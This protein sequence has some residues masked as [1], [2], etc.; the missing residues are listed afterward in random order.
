MAPL[1]VRRADFAY[2]R[3]G[4]KSPPSGTTL[5]GEVAAAAAELVAD[6]DS[7]P[8]RIVLGGRSMGGRV[9]SMA[10]AD[11]LGA[12]GL[13][14][15]AY[16]L[17]PPG[18]PEKLRTE[19]LPQID[20]PCLFVSGT[21]DPFGSPDE[22]KAATATIAGKVTHVWIDNVGHELR[23][24]NAEVASIAADWIRSL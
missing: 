21:R 20:V 22:L 14:L 24:A 19:H 3:A 16:P 18:R 11:G 2:R 7:S 13:A 1:P 6:L 15:I 12:A 4:R 8:D 5:V 9:C 17:H 10:V 23:G